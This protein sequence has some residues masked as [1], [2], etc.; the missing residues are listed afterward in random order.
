M[1]RVPRC[2]WL[3]CVRTNSVSP[4]RLRQRDQPVRGRTL[5]HASRVD[6]QSAE[7]PGARGDAA[8][9]PRNGASSAP[10]TAA[11]MIARQCAIDACPPPFAQ[12]SPEA[13]LE[14]IEQQQQR[15]GDRCDRHPERDRDGRAKARCERKVLHSPCDRS[16]PARACRATSSARVAP[17]ASRCPLNVTLATTVSQQL[18]EA[19]RSRSPRRHRASRRGCACRSGTRSA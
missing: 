12:A 5:E 11:A 17:T 9:V 13:Q 19:D 8:S 6:P 16:R 7:T 1:S 3:A 2:A 15:S 18:I 10:V 14:R 4:K